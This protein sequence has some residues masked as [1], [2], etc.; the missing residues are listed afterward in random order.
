MAQRTYR[1]DKE[2]AGRKGSHR[3]WQESAPPIW[4]ARILQVGRGETTG[5]CAEAKRLW[6]EAAMGHRW[7]PTITK[8]IQ[9]SS[10]RT[11]ALAAET[12]ALTGLITMAMEKSR[13]NGD[14]PYMELYDGTTWRLTN[15]TRKQVGLMT[16][17]R[18]GELMTDAGR[19]AD[20]E[21]LNPTC[22]C[23]KK[24]TRHRKAHDAGMPSTAQT[25]NHNATDDR[26]NLGLGTEGMLPETVNTREIHD[27]PGKADGLRSN[28]E[29]Q[30]QT[31]YPT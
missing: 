6:E 9:K 13:T 29:A 31:C 12:I 19:A 5:I 22:R 3:D 7:P 25:E 10:K 27:T 16:A 18:L 30:R 1:T 20:G 8:D 21:K 28:R 11:I 15:G 2:K 4:K 23:C 14:T 17:A 26:T 24:R